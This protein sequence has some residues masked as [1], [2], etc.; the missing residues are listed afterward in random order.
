[1]ALIKV[2]HDLFPVSSPLNLQLIHSSYR[3]ATANFPPNHFTHV[4]IDEAGHAFECEAVIGI[5][6]ILES[7]RQ[8][9]K[10]GGQLVLAGD[11]KQLGPIVRSPFAKTFGLG[12]T[13]GQDN[14]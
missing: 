2:N 9:S 14:G 3:L 5:A 13:M 8:I 6:G 1:L 12:K 11:P 7:N 4:F 10:D